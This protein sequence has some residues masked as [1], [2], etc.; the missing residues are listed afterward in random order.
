M[1]ARLIEAGNRSAALG[2]FGMKR[3]IFFCQ[4]GGYDAL[5]SNSGD[6]SDVHRF[7]REPARGTEPGLC[8]FQRAMEQLGLSN[9]VTTFTASDFGRTFRATAMAP[10]TAG[11]HTLRRRRRQWP[12]HV[13]KISDARRQWSR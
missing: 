1:I 5:G 12:P 6:R 8:S 4:V 9:N 3:Q 2:G 11:R 7:A 13:W 10:I